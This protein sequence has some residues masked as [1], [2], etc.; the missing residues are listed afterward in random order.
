MWLPIFDFLLALTK[1]PYLSR[2]FDFLFLPS[3]NI[4]LTRSIHIFYIKCIQ[5]IVGLLYETWINCVENICE[6]CVLLENLLSR[7]GL[8]KAIWG[9]NSTLCELIYSHSSDLWDIENNSLWI[10][11]NVGMWCMSVIGW[12][13][14]IILFY[15]VVMCKHKHLLFVED[16]FN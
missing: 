15:G 2:W 12:L 10:S 16:Q 7:L 9:F 4:L 1:F 11:T 8:W 3:P 14:I 5:Y 6:C 13:S